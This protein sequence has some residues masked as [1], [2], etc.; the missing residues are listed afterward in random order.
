MHA[1]ADRDED[2]ETQA[3]LTECSGAMRYQLEIMLPSG[4][5]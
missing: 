5:T 3:S 4:S 2:A 1:A